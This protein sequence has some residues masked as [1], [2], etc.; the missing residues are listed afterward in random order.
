MT[1]AYPAFTRLYRTSSPRLQVD[2]VEQPVRTWGTHTI[3]VGAGPHRVRAWVV[4]DSGTDFG[5]AEEAVV[6]EFGART[7]LSYRAPHFHGAHGRIK[8]LALSGT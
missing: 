1:F 7:E 4:P 5:V 8:V 2:G 6:V 3:A